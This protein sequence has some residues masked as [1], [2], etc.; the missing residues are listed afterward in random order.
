MNR[1]HISWLLTLNLLLGACATTPTGERPLQPVSRVDLPRYMGK[2]Y[3]IANIPTPLEKDKYAAYDF[4]ALRPD[5]T[6]DNDFHFRRGSLSAPEEK[7]DGTARVVNTTSNSE[8]RVQFFWPFSSPY[9]I[10]DLDPNYQWSLIGYPSR[11]YLWIMSRRPQLPESTYQ[12]IV[13]SAVAQ[14]YDASR[15]QRVPQL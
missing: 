15:I 5:G 6:I 9:L 12:K 13:Q 3:V 8:W 1:F 2:W 14:G 11:K 4:L 10:I 7:W